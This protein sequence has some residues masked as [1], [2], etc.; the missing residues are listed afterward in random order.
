MDEQEL[1]RG[2]LRMEKGNNP[3]TEAVCSE[4]LEP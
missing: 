4:A 1:A 2:C 3:D